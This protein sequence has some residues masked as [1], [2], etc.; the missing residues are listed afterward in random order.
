M[1]EPEA[2]ADAA[3]AMLRH[4]L[5]T[6]VYRCSKTLRGTPEEF[7]AFRAGETSRPPAEI[8]AHIGDLLNW[9]LSIARGQQT[10]SDSTPRTWEQDVDRFFEA[11]G[12]FDRFLASA[13]PLAAPPEKLF[14]GPIADALTHTG[15][16]AML[17]RMAGNPVRGENYFV[18]AI[19]AGQ[20]GPEQA[21]PKREFD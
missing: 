3:R 5:A 21:A 6:L 10:W 16:L 18:A 4:T 11:A 20:V 14:Q 15:Q 12:E 17:R 9:G 2:P 8:L 7:P 19:A 13:Q 1:A